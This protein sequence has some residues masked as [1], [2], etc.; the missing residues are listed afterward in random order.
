M[1]QNFQ[2]D[3]K[4]DSVTIRMDLQLS[5]LRKWQTRWNV[6]ESTNLTDAHLMGRPGA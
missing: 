2:T 4:E 1:I 5:F 6:W 3:P